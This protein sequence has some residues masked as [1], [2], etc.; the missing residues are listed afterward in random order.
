[1]KIISLMHTCDVSTYF[2]LKELIDQPL[3]RSVSILQPKWYVI[4]TIQPMV[5]N[6]GCMLLILFQ[7]RCLV[8]MWNNN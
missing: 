4:I 7:H 5:S 1:L 3:I 2:P 6:D 8:K